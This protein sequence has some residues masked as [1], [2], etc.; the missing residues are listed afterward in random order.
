MHDHYGMGKYIILD[1]LVVTS[2]VKS[3]RYRGAAKYE[4]PLPSVLDQS[5]RIK[6]ENQ[7]QSCG[8]VEKWRKANTF[9]MERGERE[10]AATFWR[11]FRFQTRV[12][13]ESQGKRI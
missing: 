1:T 12:A 9:S 3:G 7:T 5:E 11:L 10:R 4:N 6:Q 13:R 2:I 8:A